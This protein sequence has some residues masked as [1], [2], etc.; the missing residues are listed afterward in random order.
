MDGQ[1]LNGSGESLQGSTRASFINVTNCSKVV[2]VMSAA[3]AIRNVYAQLRQLLGDQISSTDALHFASQIV[4]F[5][6][7]RAR[8]YARSHTSTRYLLE[9][10]PFET[11]P[12]DEAM[13]DGGWRVLEYEMDQLR[14]DYD[15]GRVHIYETAANYAT[16]VFA[17][18]SNPIDSE[19]DRIL[20]SLDWLLGDKRSTNAKREQDESAFGEFF[21]FDD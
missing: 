5:C 15:I 4:L 3:P 7:R 17:A 11:W 14:P 9:E 2:Q 6:V 16:R 21:D 20:R 1:Q 18:E 8:L 12:V 19:S 10:R 13:S